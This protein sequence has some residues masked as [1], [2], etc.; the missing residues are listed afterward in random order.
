M[1]TESKVLETHIFFVMAVNVK[2]TEISLSYT[3][4]TEIS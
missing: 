3:P 4:D 2:L 1:V